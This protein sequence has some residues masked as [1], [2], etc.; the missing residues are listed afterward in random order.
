MKK[1]SSDEVSNKLSSK[2]NSEDENLQKAIL[3]AAASLNKPSSDQMTTKPENIES[4]IHSE[5]SAED[6]P[7]QESVKVFVSSWFM[8]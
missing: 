4:V 2:K 6:P 5:P 3:D 1:L 7:G 8:V